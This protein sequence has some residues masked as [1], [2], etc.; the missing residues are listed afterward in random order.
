L[1]NA[2]RPWR[3]ATVTRL[4]MNVALPKNDHGRN[5]SPRRSRFFRSSSSTP[6]FRPDSAFRKLMMRVPEVPRKT[7]SMGSSNHLPKAAML[8]TSV[9]R[10]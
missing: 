5:D 3:P 6:K 9:G 1:S 10:G 8:I 7:C 4:F 2:A